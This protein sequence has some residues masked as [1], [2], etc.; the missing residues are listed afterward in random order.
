M[1]ETHILETKNDGLY[2]WRGGG[3]GSEK[4]YCL[5][6]HENVDIFGWPLSVIHFN[7]FRR[8]NVEV[9]LGW[10]KILRAALFGEFVQSVQIY[11]ST[12]CIRVV[13][14]ME[15]YGLQNLVQASVGRKD[16]IC[17]KWASSILTVLS[18]CWFQTGS[19]LQLHP[20]VSLFLAFSNVVL[21]MLI[22][23]SFIGTV[24]YFW[25]V[26]KSCS[27]LII[28]GIIEMINYLALWGKRVGPINFNT[29][30][31]IL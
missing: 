27:F 15:D 21:F 10:A 25:Y 19:D 3:R 12:A 30:I 16:F 14:I 24:W 5:Y 11:W 26:A 20:V 18:I 7:S 31:M 17:I 23:I 28:C 22:L 2:T 8:G 6:T 4:V 13:K 29:S 9:L 1:C